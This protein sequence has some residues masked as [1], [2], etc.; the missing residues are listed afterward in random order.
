[1]KLAPPDLCDR[2]QPG[3]ALMSVGNENA[4]GVHGPCHFIIMLGI[5][6]D[7]RPLFSNA[8]ASDEILPQMKLAGGV[9]VIQSGNMGETL[10]ETIMVHHLVQGLLGAGRKNGL[11]D[12]E[13]LGAVQDSDNPIV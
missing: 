1:M 2:L 5:A 6:H 7:H 10:A 9:N 12:P 13:L 8:Q 3:F 4:I 11:A